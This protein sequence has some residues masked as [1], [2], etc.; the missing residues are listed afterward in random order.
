[1][2]GYRRRT[3]GNSQVVLECKDK[4]I[5]ISEYPWRGN[6]EGTPIIILK[7]NRDVELLKVNLSTLTIK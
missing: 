3:K 1:M 4:V 5:R 7:D 2:E 6:K